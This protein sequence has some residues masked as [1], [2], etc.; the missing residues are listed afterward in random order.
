MNRRSFL[1]AI[2]VAFVW[3]RT[4][5]P[6]T[7]QLGT[8]FQAHDGVMWF[9]RGVKTSDEL[10]FGWTFIRDNESTHRQP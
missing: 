2:F 6:F 10:Q 8:Y 5:K 4:S 7:L 9:R 1:A 3:P